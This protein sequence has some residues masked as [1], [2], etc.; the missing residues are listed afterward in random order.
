MG[1]LNRLGRV[2]IAIFPLAEPSSLVIRGTSESKGKK[3]EGESRA[4]NGKEQNWSKLDASQR[5]KKY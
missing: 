2:S 1:G 4:P 3:Q 5:S